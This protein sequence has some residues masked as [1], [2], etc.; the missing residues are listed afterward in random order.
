MKETLLLLAQIK[1][2]QAKVVDEISYL[3]RAAYETKDPRIA[4]ELGKRLTDLGDYEHAFIWYNYVINSPG[5][6]EI[7]RARAAMYAGIT[8]ARFLDDTHRAHEYWQIVVEKFYNSAFIPRAADFLLGAVDEKTFRT[9]IT[10]TPETEAFGEYVIGLK[11]RTLADKKA[12]ANAFKRC[13]K[14][15]S[16]KDPQKMRIPQKWAWEDLQRLQDYNGS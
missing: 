12:A 10:A 6:E 16:E 15:S 14:L 7:L 8:A 9:Q 5:V 2:G 13:L 1:R 4:I 11:H 3:S